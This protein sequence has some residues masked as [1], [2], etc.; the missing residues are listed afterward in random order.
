VAVKVADGT[1]R[2][3]G[4]ALIHALAQLDVLDEG[5]VD[6]LRPHA[7]PDILGGGRAVGEMVASFDLT[8]G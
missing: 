8:G 6:R 3:A 7:R 4:T 2:G 5:Q 1:A